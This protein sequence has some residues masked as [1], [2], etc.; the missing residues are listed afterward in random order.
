MIGQIIKTAGV[1]I[2]PQAS[3]SL[4]SFYKQSRFVRAIYIFSLQD[5]IFWLVKKRLGTSGEFEGEGRRQLRV[6]MGK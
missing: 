3:G 2:D 4:L 1:I 6:W 5:Q